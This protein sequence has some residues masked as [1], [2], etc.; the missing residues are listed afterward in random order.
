M[1]TEFVSSDSNSSTAPPFGISLRKRAL[2]QIFEWRR[3]MRER[4]ELANLSV[5]DLK[6]IG[7]PAGAAAE[8]SK[9]FWEA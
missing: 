3:R 2:D 5:H 8:Q 9:P 4:C 1:T 7:Y 6:D